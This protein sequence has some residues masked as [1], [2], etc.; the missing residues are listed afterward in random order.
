MVR[1]YSTIDRHETVVFEFLNVQ[2]IRPNYCSDVVD[3]N[4]LA[5]CRIL[6]ASRRLLPERTVTYLCSAY[7]RSWWPNHLAAQP[8]V[9][10]ANSCGAG[11]SWCELLRQTALSN[12]TAVGRV[13]RRCARKYGPH[14]LHLIGTLPEEVSRFLNGTQLASLR[15]RMT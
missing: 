2:T 11:F 3:P 8:I 15:N 14:C 9:H 4:D 13:D 12:N 7:L 6:V 10:L 5:F 1:K